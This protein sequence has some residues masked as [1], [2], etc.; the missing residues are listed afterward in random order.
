[1]Y[2]GMYGYIDL[3]NNNVGLSWNLSK[4]HNFLQAQNDIGYPY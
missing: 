1:M 4:M 2:G 3:N